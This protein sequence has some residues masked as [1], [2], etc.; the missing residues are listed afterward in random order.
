MKQITYMDALREAFIEEMERD[1]TVFLIGES[2]QAGSYDITSGIVQRFGADRV[3]DTPIAEAGI[4]GAAVGAATAGYRPIADLMFADFMMIAGDE[5]FFKAAQWRFLHGG[6]VSVPAVFFAAVGAG[7]ALANEH[8]QVP[9]AYFLHSAGLKVVLPSTPYDAKGLLKTAIRDDNPVIFLWHK[10]LMVD[11]GEIPE[12]EYT[13]PF[14][15]AD[16]KREGKDVTV[17]ANSY[18]VQQTLTVA[19]QLKGKIDVEVIDPRTLEP[20][21]IETILKSVE[22]TG[23]LVVVDEDTERC[24]FAGEL[25]A[26]VVD[27]G[28]DLLDA[29]IKRV[30]A[31]NFPIPGGYMEPFVIPQPEWIQKA[32]EDV[33]A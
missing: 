9:S 33:A 6:K 4:A 10:M 16:I 15:V 17:V 14:G 21:D 2:V 25:C 26:Q 8:S 27:R 29:P 24:G 19:D 13:I 22:K 30:C 11:Q 28:F 3:M 7:E 20:L 1:D 12:E 5:I 31:K 23:H 18:M 32:I